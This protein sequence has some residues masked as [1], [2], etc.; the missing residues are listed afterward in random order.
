VLER[1]LEGASAEPL[2]ADHHDSAAAPCQ[3]SAAALGSIH[4]L[5][6]N[7]ATLHSHPLVSHSYRVSPLLLF[8]A[9]PPPAR[10]GDRDDSK[11]FFCP[12]RCVITKGGVFLS[13]KEK[14][15]GSVTGWTAMSYWEGKCLVSSGGCVAR[16][17][18]MRGRS[19]C[20]DGLMA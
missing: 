17:L 4:R 7:L 3:S 1:R 20:L 18:W 11:R 19:M 13:N 16:C 8:Y 10:V 9:P 12:Q 5:D 6:P 14:T 15:D 2:V